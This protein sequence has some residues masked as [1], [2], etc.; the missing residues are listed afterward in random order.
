MRIII[1]IRPFERNTYKGS[2]PKPLRMETSEDQLRE[3][4][5]IRSHQLIA[6][7][8]AT[9]NILCLITRIENLVIAMPQPPRI[10]KV[11][12]VQ[13]DDGYTVK[14]KEKQASSTN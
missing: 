9:R 14:R 11:F 5:R 2:R 8:I 13:S 3:M 1:L 10:M 4:H 7:P 6:T 12:T